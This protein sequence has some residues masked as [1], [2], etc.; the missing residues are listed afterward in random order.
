[1]E[2]EQTPVVEENVSSSGL[3]ITS[4]VSGSVPNMEVDEGLF[5]PSQD[6]ASALLRFL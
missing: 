6:E 2:A 3:R 4:I 5:S 1:M